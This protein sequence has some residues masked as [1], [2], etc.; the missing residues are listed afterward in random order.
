MRASW[1]A[2]TLSAECFVTSFPATCKI[3]RLGVVP[4]GNILDILPCMVGISAPLY[5]YDV[6]GMPWRL[7]M[8]PSPL[9]KEVPMMMVSLESLCTVGSVTG[10]IGDLSLCA[11]VLPWMASRWRAA[12]PISIT[13]IGRGGDD[14]EGRCD[15]G[16][17]DIGAAVEDRLVTTEANDGCTVL[18]VVWVR[19]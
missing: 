13:G 6:T 11:V 18:M 16:L 1:R 8:G 14:A 10:C 15:K 17:G 12:A 2:A 4:G 5:M 7:S 19:D 9:M 3:I